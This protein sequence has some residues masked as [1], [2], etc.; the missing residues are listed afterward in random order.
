MFKFVEQQHEHGQV[1]TM[2]TAHGLIA[3]A[4][5]CCPDDD[6]KMEAYQFAKVLLGEFV[7]EDA[8]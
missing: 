8:T 7:T 6:E 1:N 2:A 4:K 5:A 3:I